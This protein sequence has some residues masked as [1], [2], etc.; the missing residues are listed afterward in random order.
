MIITVYLIL[1]NCSGDSPTQYE[2]SNS[3]RAY[4]ETNY[5]DLFFG[6]NGYETVG[7]SELIAALQAHTGIPVEQY[8]DQWIK[9]N[10]KI[11]LSIKNVVIQ[12]NGN[13]YETSVEFNAE[14][15]KDYEIFTALGYRTSPEGEMTII[16]VNTTKTGSQSLSFTSDARPL[17]IQLDPDFRVPQVA[18]NNDSW[19]R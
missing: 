5:Y 2:Y 11:D 18:L 1:V 6:M 7:H 4:F 12:Q 3:P 13:G 17:Y 16:E 14:S 8:L 15:D 19:S 10:A 9:N